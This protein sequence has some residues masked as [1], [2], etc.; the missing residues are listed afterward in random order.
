MNRRELIRNS[1]L[2]I[3]AAATL[4]PSVEALVFPAG[5]N[6]WLEL[7]RPDWKPVFLSAQQNELLISL[8]EALIPATDTPG[9]K[10]AFVNRF[11]DL[12]LSVLPSGAQQEFLSSLQWFD[13]GAQQRYKAGFASLSSEEANDFLSLV[14]WPHTEYRWGERDAEFDGHAHF[15]KVKSWVAAAYY[16]SPIGLQ[17][18]GWDGWAARGIFE[19]CEHQPGEHQ[20]AQ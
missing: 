14:A 6:A 13:A 11:L 4:H 5:D 9:A 19:G 10:A 3:G 16:S 20:D 12:L 18:L 2:T 17:E 8:S 1:L 15:E 7:S